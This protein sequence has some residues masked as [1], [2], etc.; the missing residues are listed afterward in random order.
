MKIIIT[1][2]TILA[3]LTATAG[4]LSSPITSP[5]PEPRPMAS[6]TSASGWAGGY[7]GLSYGTTKATT[8]TPDRDVYECVSGDRHDTVK[9]WTVGHTNSPEINALQRVKNPWNVSEYRLGE[10]FGAPVVYGDAPALWMPVNSTF[11]Y[12]VDAGTPHSLQ[13]G[14]NAQINFIET[15][16]ETVT[17]TEGAGAFIGYRWDVGPVVAGIEAT[18]SSMLHTAEASLGIPMGN[19]LGY[20]FAGA[21][22]YDGADGSVYGVGADLRVTDS[23]TV[24][25]KG[26]WGEFGDTTT[27]GAALRVSFS[28]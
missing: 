20:A 13:P 1:A 5:R 9:C 8:D 11:R 26:T 17:Q 14:K 21:G 16:T 19:A 22:Q 3:P 15:I 4:G 18:T 12:T 24:G 7:V 6:S 10:Q 28:F 23:V 25:I 2:L 27:E